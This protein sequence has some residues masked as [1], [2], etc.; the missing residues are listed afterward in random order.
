M[1]SYVTALR[2]ARLFSVL[3]IASPVLIGI[4]TGMYGSP[5]L[6]ASL[7][8]LWLIVVICLGTVNPYGRVMRQAYI[9]DL[10]SKSPYLRVSSEK[11]LI[12]YWIRG[13]NTMSTADKY[14]LPLRVVNDF[15][16]Q[17][18]IGF[19]RWEKTRRSLLE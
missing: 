4:F 15:F 3:T 2:K 11:R 14:G 1:K 13:S 16:A 9:V 17:L 6:F 19:K 12:K 5:I 18:E 7:I 8:I 10:I